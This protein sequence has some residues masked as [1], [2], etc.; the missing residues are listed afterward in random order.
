DLSDGT[1][2]EFADAHTL[3]R[4]NTHLISRDVFSVRAGD[5]LFYRQLGQNMPFHA[6]I[7][8]G[9]SHFESDT[10]PRVVYHT[11]PSGQ[12]EGEIRRPTL[13]GLLNH[14]EPRW[15]P[16]VANSNFMGV[17]RWNILR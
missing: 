14:P 12:S 2:A 13:N 1:F 9:Q 15:R 5:L 11:G 3:Q 4:F 17:Y 8:I 10:A 16:A 6:M 7:Y